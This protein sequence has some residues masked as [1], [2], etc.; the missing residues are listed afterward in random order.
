M[1][2]IVKL[3]NVYQKKQ[4]LLETRQLVFIHKEIFA[5][6]DVPISFRSQIIHFGNS[7]WEYPDFTQ[8]WLSSFEELLAQLIWLSATVSIETEFNG[9]YNFEWYLDEA[10]LAESYLAEPAKPTIHWIRSGGLV[11][12]K[13]EDE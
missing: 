2:T 13:N 9:S 1:P 7:Y 6:S 4:S 3:L 5:I 12:E 8:G 11:F 10:Y